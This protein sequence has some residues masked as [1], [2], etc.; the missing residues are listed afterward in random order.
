MSLVVLSSSNLKYLLG[1]SNV[2]LVEHNVKY[3]QVRQNVPH[4]LNQWLQ[5]MKEHVFLHVLMV[6]TLLLRLIHFVN[7]ALTKT[8][9][10]AT[11]QTV[12]YAN[13]ISQSP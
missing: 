11:L 5:T 12:L 8:V 6:S 1:Y 9:N 13:P 7:H 2:N 10:C 3:V 4:V